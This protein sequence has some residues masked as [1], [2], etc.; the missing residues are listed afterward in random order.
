MNV[1]ILPSTS[2]SSKSVSIER[3]SHLHNVKHV[4]FAA[5]LLYELPKTF[6]VVARIKFIAIPR[7]LSK[8]I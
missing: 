5:T 3:H 6:F 2:H 8:L 7:Y 4:Y 1:G